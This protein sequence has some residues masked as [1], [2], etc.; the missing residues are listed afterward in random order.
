MTGK[1][2][3]KVQL[4]SKVINRVNYA[5]TLATDYLTEHKNYPMP[6]EQESLENCCHFT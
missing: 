5:H 4:Q 2:T 6:P 3:G 1:V